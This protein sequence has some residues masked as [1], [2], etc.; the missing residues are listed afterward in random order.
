MGA[1]RLREQ[2]DDAFERAMHR[3]SDLGA[4]ESDMRDL[5]SLVGD[6]IFWIE[7]HENQTCNEGEAN[8]MQRS[9][10]S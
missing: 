10:A 3:G 6:I 1:E 4:L 9:R 7:E 2:F 8:E 5:R